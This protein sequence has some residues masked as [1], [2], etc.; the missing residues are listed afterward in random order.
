[1][2]PAKIISKEEAVMA[3]LAKNKKQKTGKG[4]IGGGVVVQVNPDGKEEEMETFIINENDEKILTFMH[5][6]R[7]QVLKKKRQFSAYIKQFDKIP[8]G[9]K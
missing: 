3:G 7:A 5:K 8:R 9:L 4:T 1:M 2:I 6:K